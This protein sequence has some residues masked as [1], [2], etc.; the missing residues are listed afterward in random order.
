[1][2]GASVRPCGRQCK[3]DAARRRSSTKDSISALRRSGSG[4]RRIEGDSA[5]HQ[6]LGGGG[7]QAHQLIRNW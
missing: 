5:A 6:G 2:T 3:T 7:S 4:A 1:M